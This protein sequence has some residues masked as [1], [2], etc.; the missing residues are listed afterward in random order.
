MHEVKKI[1]SLQNALIRQVVQLKHKNKERDKTGLFVLEGQRELYM[2]LQGGYQ[3]NTVL[4]YPEFFPTGEVVQFLEEFGAPAEIIEISREVYQKLA[5]REKTEGILAVAKARNH[6]LEALNL[7][8]EPLILVAEAVEKPGNLGALLR[9]ADA[10]KLDAVIIAD[11]KG[12][13]YNPN[14][15]RSSVG[16]IFTVPIAT[17]S[18]QEVLDFLKPHRVRI[19]AATLTEATPYTQADFKGGCA[20]A[21]GTESTGLSLFWVNNADARI[22][23]PMEGQIDSMNVS[24]SAAILIFEAKRQRL[25]SAP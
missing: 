7:P 19:Y 21:V 17:A 20:I 2:A 16:C 12:D 23:I 4:I 15:I 25:T 24:V 9:T 11:P 1:T 18:S 10:A 5:Y 22:V 13:L 14:T 8:D 3:I 6:T